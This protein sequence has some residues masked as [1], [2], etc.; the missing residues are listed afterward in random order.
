[1]DNQRPPLQK[2]RKSAFLLPLT[3][4]FVLE[5]LT[6]PAVHGQQFTAI[7]STNLI[8]GKSGDLRK[9]ITIVIEGERIVSIGLSDTTAIPTNARIIDGRQRWVIPGLIDVHTHSTSAARLAQALAFGITTVHAMPMLPDT[10]IDLQYKSWIASMASPRIQMTTP[11]FSGDF[12]DNIFPAVYHFR[13]PRTADEARH[14]V[15]TYHGIGHRQIK[16]I[17]DDGVLFCGLTKVAPRLS[18]DVY[19]ALVEEARRL[20]M[21]VYVHTTQIVDTRQAA[22][23]GCDILMH[24]TFD[25]LVDERLWADIKHSETVWAPACSIFP[26]L[27]EPA[28]YARRILA[29]SRLTSRLTDKQLETCQKNAREATPSK[30]MINLV[31]NYSHFWDVLASN[32]RAARAHGVTIAVGSDQSAGLH[33]HMEMELLSE[34]GLSPAEVLVAATSSAARALELEQQIGTVE[35]GMIADLI[36][37]RSNPLLDIRNARDAQLIIKGGRLYSPDDLIKQVRGGR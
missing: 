27:A 4:F 23:A 22:R 14:W 29:D 37:L 6:F 13:K 12:P 3:V 34:L 8:D 32:T 19:R 24:A 18:T 7:K 5:C 28:Q 16:I 11:L 33:T 36:V 9:N 2:S 15:R 1:M 30:V 10:L 17:Q 31:A 35:S 21:R 26:S 20:G 25:S